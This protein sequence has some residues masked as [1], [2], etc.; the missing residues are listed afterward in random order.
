[1]YKKRVSN[2]TKALIRACLQHSSDGEDE[3]ITDNSG[4]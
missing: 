2:R 1:M 3:N 4:K